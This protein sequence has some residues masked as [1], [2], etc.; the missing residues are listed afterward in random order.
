MASFFTEFKPSFIKFKNEYESH[1][2]N[3]TQDVFYQNGDRT[4]SD[5]EKYY[6]KILTDTSTT[7]YF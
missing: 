4:F 6:L 1:K 7:F 3:N 5:R 2:A